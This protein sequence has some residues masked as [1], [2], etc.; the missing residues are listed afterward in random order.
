M[1]LRMLSALGALAALAV[2]VTAVP[3]SGSNEAAQTAKYVV[4]LVQAPAAGYEGDIAGY[5][6]TKPAKGKKY[7]STTQ[8]VAKYTGLLV[9]QH[10]A[11]LAKVGGGAKLYD[12]V[13]SVNGF[14]AE[15]TAAQAD[16][17]AGMGSVLS[18][19]KNEMLSLDTS[20]TP[21]FLGLTK[22]A[23]EGGLWAKGIT[24][25]G[26]VI[27]IVDGG[28]WPES[29]SYSDRTGTGPNGQAGKLAYQ[30]LPGW[31]GKCQ[32]GEAFNASMCNQKVIGARFYTAGVG[33]TNIPDYEFAS[34]RD[35][36]GHG[37]HTSSTAG[38]N[39]GVQATGDA[40]GFGKISGM[41]PR[42]RLAI[43]KACWVLPGSPSGSCSSLDTTAAIDQAV[44]DG[45]DAL[46][47][48]ISGTS[49]AFTNSVEVSFLFAAEAGVYVSASAGNSGPTAG[50]VAHP[51]PWITTTA[52]GTHN[53]D[54][55]GTLEIDSAIYNGAS[56]AATAVT[57]EL[58]DAETATNP[59]YVL[60]NPIPASYPTTIPDAVRLC[61]P[62][63]L[64]PAKVAGKIVV[65]DRG[66]IGR[67]DKSLAV[68]E[69]GGDGMVMVNTSPN[70]I[71]ADLHF[72]PSIHLQDTDRAAVKAAAAAHKQATISVGTIV[73][74][75][76]APFTASFSSRGPITAGGGD[77]LKP[78][79]MA[80][81]QDILAVV[82]PPG[83]HGRN[84][85][86]YSGTSMSSPHM[87]GLGALLKQAHPD[88]SPMMIKSAFMTTSY[89]TLSTGGASDYSPF[90][91]GA[92][93]VDPNKAIDPGLVFDSNFADWI[94]FLRGQKLVTSPGVALDASDLNSASIAIG[95]L[96]GIQSVSRT[97]K[98]VGS[99]SET[100]TRSVVGLTG[101]TVDAPASF[102]IA[103]GAT[104]AWTATFTRTDAAALGT[105]KTGFIVW[106]GNKGHVVKMPV[107][108]R[109]VALAAPVEVS[110][111]GGTGGTGSVTYDT[112]SGFTG[113]LSY[114]ILGLQ[115][116]TKFDNT[117][118]T[119]PACSFD[120]THPDD[121]V[122]ANKATVNSFTTPADAKLIR[123]QTFQSDAS[124]SAHDLDMFVY[125]AP[126]APAPEVYTLVLTSG[127]G[128]TNEVTT[129]T[130]AGSLATGARFKV[131]M[132]ACGV[133]GSGTFTL[134]AW[135]L[136]GTASNAFT[137]VPATTA[138]SIGQ[139]VPTTLGW[140]ALAA[141][142]RYL[143][144]VQYNASA[145]PPASNPVAQT[146]VTVSTR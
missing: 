60:P 3:A 140:T 138:V 37:S 127:G 115:A 57:A 59:A 137:T 121:M 13:H 80:P 22:P 97:A 87:T 65:C 125:R 20:S 82:A 98:S 101:I 50:T 114:G 77:I 68:H 119:D 136:T 46:N 48:S 6:R 103:P 19:E 27:G 79:I 31:N 89:Q 1:R 42:A 71:N 5:E 73:N 95:D 112:K 15:L 32:P 4:T 90:N 64:D 104:Q 30:Q 132:H 70:S 142:N 66:I 113:D 54:G 118:G 123:F 26:V 105:Y 88:W 107:V 122:T 58:V 145:L 131:Y 51:S 14:A 85:D 108:I 11:L 10:D 94:N 139:T 81:G 116:A 21:D 49:T 102:T 117:I 8:A 111:A 74:N 43:Y 86:L 75:A 2:V 78:D 91:W 100:Y 41:A 45:V 9:G 18:V 109:P 55:V 133:D 84:F 44:A 126:P 106:T 128:D 34:P 129:S 144:R 24:G 67:I 110:A 99:E 69:A 16:K 29:P 124:A 52:A 72:V 146:I 83:N 130:S 93:H 38:G 28:F 92:G 53:R 63:A 40:A 56:S 25:E 76:A 17:L 141:G 23:N 36:G 143:G 7:D 47:Y 12:Y 135:A 120:T 39:S 61:T 96:A 134:F 33:E 35:Y 62:G